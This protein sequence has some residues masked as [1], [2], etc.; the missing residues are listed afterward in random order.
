[1]KDST[2]VVSRVLEDGTLIETLFDGT[3]SLLAVREA[4][5]ST[6]VA[7][8]YTTPAGERLV[9]YSATNNLLTSGCVLLPSAIGEVGDKGEMVRA[10]GDYLDR[11]VDLSPGMRA[12]APYYVL[13]TW[14]YD[15]FAE[16]PYL[17]FR[18]DWGSGK[19]RCLL[20][21][22]S[23]CYKPFFASGASTV[24]PIFHILDAVGGTMVLDEADL[25]FSDTTADLVKVLNNGNMRGLPVLRTMTNKN[26]ELNPQAFSVFGP[27]VL[28]MRESFSDAAL[29]S[30]FVTE[31]TSKR[32]LP[33]HIPI[34]LPKSLSAE[35]RDLRN[36]LLS[37]RLQHFNDIEPN[38]ERL[39]AGAAAR[40]N[41]TALALLSLIDDPAVRVEAA[42]VFD[43]GNEALGRARRE[44]TEGQVVA[45][46]LT[47]LAETNTSHVPLAHV[48]EAFFNSNAG[49]PGVHPNP[50]WVGLTVRKLG[51]QT[52]KSHGVYV[53]P[54]TE[55]AR[56]LKLADAYGFPHAM[57]TTSAQDADL[58][59][60]P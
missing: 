19:T 34:H 7:D 22:G 55:H 8:I 48:A 30:R 44:T 51:V 2:P 32:P 54:P 36:R 40:T 3:T 49:K 1:M 37:W 11:Y 42:A 47:A 27:K 26:R 33:P 45:A 60:S 35:A 6:S 31:E 9:P 13:L 25:R 38:P 50:K 58:L 39:I 41:Q 28:A 14:V 43:E 15:A 59:A 52:R 4:G 17:R 21:I 23:I 10:I 46:L 20:T 16:L 56:I 57:T 5:G 29:E 18:G 12:L 53:I 24:S